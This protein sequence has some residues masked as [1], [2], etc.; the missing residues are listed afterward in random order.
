MSH[1]C[2]RW[3]LSLLSPSYTHTPHRD[4]IHNFTQWE[5]RFEPLAPCCTSLGPTVRWRPIPPTSCLNY[6]LVEEGEENAFSFDPNL[7]PSPREK[8]MRVNVHLCSSTSSFFF[9]F[10]QKPLT[11]V[12]MW[13]FFFKFIR[14]WQNYNKI[15]ITGVGWRQRCDGEGRLGDSFTIV[16]WCGDARSPGLPAGLLT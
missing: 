16:W 14:V 13:I 3:T 4:S 6:G 9:F 10:T 2:V 12:L 15:H 7:P 8:M 11:S 1:E 5:Q